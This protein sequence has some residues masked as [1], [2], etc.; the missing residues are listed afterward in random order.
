MKQTLTFIELG[1][2][3]GLFQTFQ[4]PPEQT[5]V[6]DVKVHGPVELR[7]GE[8]CLLMGLHVLLQ[9]PADLRQSLGLRR[10]VQL[11]CSRAAGLQEGS[12]ASLVCLQHVSDLSQ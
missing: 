4:W 9:V 7:V 12:L 11:A 2:G 6:A 10:C 8:T 1:P 3:Q 5:K